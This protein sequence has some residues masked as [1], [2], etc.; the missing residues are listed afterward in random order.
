MKKKL[1]YT[2]FCCVSVAASFIIVL[3]LDGVS[4]NVS[5]GLK[6]KKLAS[7]DCK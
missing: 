4:I 2:I 6:G 5:A 7:K 1:S 3:L